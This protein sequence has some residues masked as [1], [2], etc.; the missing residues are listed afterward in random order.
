M[1][2]VWEW[3]LTLLAA[4]G[5]FSLGWLLFGRLL[6]PVGTT[7]TPLYLVVRGEG[8]GRGLEHTVSALVWLRSREGLSC[9]L[10]LVDGGL[11][12]E[13]RTLA[14]LLARRWPEVRLCGPEELGKELN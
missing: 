12:D 5:L 14:A 13:G 1:M 8:S 4:F 3:V 2:T 6:S 10:L 11:N 7:E 9:P